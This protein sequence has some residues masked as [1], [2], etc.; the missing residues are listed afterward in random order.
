MS[1]DISDKEL[2]HTA[3]PWH[4]IEGV[5]HLSIQGNRGE[6]IILDSSPEQNRERKTIDYKRIVACVNACSGLSQ[7]AF[8]GGW[9]AAGMSRYAAKLE[10]QLAAIKI[11]VQKLR[12]ANFEC[13]GYHETDTNAPVF[14]RHHG[15]GYDDA[16][17]DVQEI[18]EAKP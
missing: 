2:Q 18:L 17:G 9:T 16:L 14:H 12:D 15:E 11:E 1:L 13:N 4:L 5:T 6:T 8:D 7:F 3:D 10:G